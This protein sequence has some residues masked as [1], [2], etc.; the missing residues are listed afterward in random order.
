MNRFGVFTLA[1]LVVGGVACSKGRSTTVSTGNGTATVTQSQDN[2]TTTVTSKE[3]TMIAGKNAV[4]P[5]TLGVPVYTG[6]TQQ[7][8]GYSITDAQGGGQVVALKTPDAFDK[9]YAFYKSQLPPSAETMKTESNGSAY[10]LFR[11]G[12][13]KNGATIVLEQK[14]GDATTTIVITKATSSAPAAAST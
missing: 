1:L 7:E 9:V 10:A 11:V 3:G 5:A 12:T 4:D 13:D 14:Q 6:A 8:G 2:Q